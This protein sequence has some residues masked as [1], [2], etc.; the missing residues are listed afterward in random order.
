MCEALFLE[1]DSIDDFV[2]CV[3][4]ILCMSKVTFVCQYACSLNHMW[5]HSSVRTGFSVECTGLTVECTGLTMEC[6]GVL[7]TEIWLCNRSDLGKWE[8]LREVGIKSEVRQGRGGRELWKG[9]EVSEEGGR[10]YSIL[11]NRSANAYGRYS[12]HRS[13]LKPIRTEQNRIE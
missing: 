5:V 3:T 6:P 7:L 9:L 10:A 12:I 1:T 4:M 13:S 2:Q 11:K 8:D